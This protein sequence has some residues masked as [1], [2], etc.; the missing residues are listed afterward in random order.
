MR[1]LL[2]G[3][4]ITLS[5]IKSSDFC[6][7]E[8]WFNNTGFLRYYDT[9]PA[10]PQSINQI[11]ALVKDFENSSEKYMFAIRLSSNGKIIG[12]TGFDSIIWSCGVATA[13]IGIG[14]DSFIGKGLGKEAMQLLIDYGFNELNFHRIQLNTISYN[15]I[16]I[17]LYKGMGF[18][19]EGTYREH[20]LRDGKRY[21]LYMFGMLSSEWRSINGM[22]K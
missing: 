19:K 2:V 4:T 5:A 9:L 11:D 15:E 10:I 13:F 8:N 1:N 21:D 20:V 6:I 17:G 22:C 12:I 18:V 16:A 7:M 14:D 3:K